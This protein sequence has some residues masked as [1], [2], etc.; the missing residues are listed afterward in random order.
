MYIHLVVEDEL[1]EVI[2]R[3]ILGE[4]ITGADVHVVTIGRKGKG[5]IKKRI[6][7]FNNQDN[8]LPFFVLTDL[9]CVT[10]AP[11]LIQQWLKRPCR[12]NLVFRVAVREVEAWLLADSHGISNYLNMDHSY[13]SKEVQYPD[14]LSD[15][16]HKLL[17]L[18]ERS[19]KRNMISDIVKNDGSSLKQGPGYNTRLTDFVVNDW[20][21]ER[22]R[23]NSDSFNRAINAL[24]KLT[25]EESN[26]EY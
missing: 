4:Y 5:Y 18:V 10:C 20:N 21:M 25:R 17:S 1:S 24:R 8:D 14:N 15:P 9:D 16:K 3:K 19:K 13:I 22:A 7:E 23:S 11:E 12:K 6:N 2:S 26:E